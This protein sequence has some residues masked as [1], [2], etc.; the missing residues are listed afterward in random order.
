MGTSL[1]QATEMLA[2]Y[3]SA[4]AAILKGQAYQIGN[5]SVTRAD[6]AEIRKGRIEWQRLVD[7]I[8]TGSG[9][10]RVKRVMPVDI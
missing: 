5:R 3:I 8:S 10:P 4:E 6:L 2:A 9:A 7:R 1:V